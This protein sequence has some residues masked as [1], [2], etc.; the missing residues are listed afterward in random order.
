M[1]FLFLICCI[2]W[3]TLCSYLDEYKPTIVF[4][5]GTFVLEANMTF[6]GVLLTLFLTYVP[7][8]IMTFLFLILTEHR[9]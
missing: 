6:F 4:E 8:Q 2:F 7:Y 3:L 9:L 5:K 1:Q